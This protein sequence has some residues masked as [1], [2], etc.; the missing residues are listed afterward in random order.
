[1][2]SQRGERRMPLTYTGSGWFVAAFVNT[3][4]NDGG[5]SY[6]ETTNYNVIWS[7]NWGRNDI[8]ESKY[9]QSEIHG[10][11]DYP[12]YGGD[13]DLDLERYWSGSTW[14]YWGSQTVKRDSPYLAVQNG[15]SSWYN[16]D[17]K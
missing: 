11:H 9:D 12:Y 17:S 5:F 7:Y 16:Y 1:M 14:Y 13:M 15:N 3:N 2:A 8:S 4:N 10:D 6:F